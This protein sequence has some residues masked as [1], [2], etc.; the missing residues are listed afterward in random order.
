[1]SSQRIE[2][3]ISVASRARGCR[4]EETKR[5]RAVEE[6]KEEKQEEEEK[7]EGGGGVSGTPGWN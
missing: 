6:E 2:T 1:M 4:Y 3:L 7:D 5:D